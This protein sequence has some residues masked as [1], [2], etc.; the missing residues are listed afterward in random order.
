MTRS[1][2]LAYDELGGCQ[3]HFLL[4]PFRVWMGVVEREVIVMIL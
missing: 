1:N 2:S 4:E 3:N